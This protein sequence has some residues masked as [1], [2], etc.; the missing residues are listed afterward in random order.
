MS[1]NHTP[2]DILA[3]GPACR[4]NGRSRF[5]T[6][7]ATGAL[8]IPPDLGAEIEQAL[9]REARRIA[10]RLYIQ[11]PLL[12]FAKLCLDIAELRLKGK[13]RALHLIG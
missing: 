12:Y 5:I 1:T 13:R 4:L 2:K 8:E 9:R 7:P 10:L 3:A 11:L 6:N